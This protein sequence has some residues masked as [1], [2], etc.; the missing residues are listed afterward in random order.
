MIKNILNDKNIDKDFKNAI[1]EQEFDK[2]IKE[3]INLYKKLQENIIEFS[4]LQKMIK[5]NEDF[6]STWRNTKFSY[7]KDICLKYNESDLLNCYGDIFF[8]DEKHKDYYIGRRVLWNLELSKEQ[9]Y[10]DEIIDCSAD[11][12]YNFTEYKVT[13]KID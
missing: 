8:I 9:Y 7:W 3:Q 1:S 6:E 12:E 13:V 5:S 4:R 11:G 10:I 2:H